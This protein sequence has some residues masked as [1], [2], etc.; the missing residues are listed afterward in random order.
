MS[1]TGLTA[2]FED[3]RRRVEDALARLV[4]TAP[5]CPPLLAEAMRYALLAGAELATMRAW[6]MICLGFA[7]LWIGSEKHLVHML[8]AAAALILLHDPRAIGDI[9]FQLSFLSVLAIIWVIDEA[10]RWTKKEESVH[11]QWRSWTMYL[12]EAIASGA[13]VTLI[14]IPLVAWYFNQVP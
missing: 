3:A 8:A 12:V 2:F 1:D 5:D 11:S 4:P 6:I 14:T 7:A 13:A 10:S 9:S